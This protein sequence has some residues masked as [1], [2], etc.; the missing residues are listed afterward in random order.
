MQTTP[1]NL[2]L[3]PAVVLIVRKSI[4]MGLVPSETTETFDEKVDVLY[5]NCLEDYLQNLWDEA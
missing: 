4:E 3:L 1:T 2:D 5:G